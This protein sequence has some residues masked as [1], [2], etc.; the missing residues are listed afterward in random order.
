M[1]SPTRRSV[2]RSSL[3]LA[4]AGSLARPHIAN[5]QAKTA[6]VWWVQGFVKEEELNAETFHKD[7]LVVIASANHRLAAKSQIPLEG[8]CKSA[9]IGAFMLVLVF[10]TSV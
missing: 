9:R 2:L 7:E 5:A 8:V 10:S 6:E 3:A 1:T 4:A